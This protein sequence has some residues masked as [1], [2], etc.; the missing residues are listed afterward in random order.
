MTA[1]TCLWLWCLTLGSLAAAQ[2]PAGQT[3]EVAGD[4]VHVLIGQLRSAEW[5]QRVHAALSLANLNAQE[6]AQPILDRLE[7][8]VKLSPEQLAQRGWV[9]KRD[10]NDFQAVSRRLKRTYL[11]CLAHLGPVSEPAVR[12]LL[13][14]AQPPLSSYLWIL[15]ATWK[16]MDALEPVI[17][18]LNGDKD[19]Y[20]RAWAATALGYLGSPKAIP[21]LQAAKDDTFEEWNGDTVIELVSACAVGALSKLGVVLKPRSVPEAQRP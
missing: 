4:Q 18:L 21:A 12:A 20:I 3:G 17:E 5:S 2:Q 1:R 14:E 7:E 15:L 9:E 10:S 16:Q 13:K 8:E 19:P 6:A 11:W